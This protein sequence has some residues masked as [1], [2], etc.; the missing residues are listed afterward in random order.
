MIT[1][2]QYSAALKIIHDY[3]IQVKKE[4]YE[5]QEIIKSLPK[6]SQATTTTKILD[7]DISTRLIHAMKAADC[8]N[9][10]IGELQEME[11]RDFMRIRNFGWR[12]MNELNEIF[13]S[14]GLK[15]KTK[16]K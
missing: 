11:W 4:F 13:I 16:Y 2:K 1:F 6:Y 5:S 9:K 3:H 7:L 8:E 10:T 12:S 15:P 14:V